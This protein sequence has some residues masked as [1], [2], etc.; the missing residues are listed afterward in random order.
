[1]EKFTKIRHFTDLIVWQEAHKLVLIIYK[2]TENFPQKEIFGIT[3]QVRRAITSVTANI[4]EGFSRFSYKDRIRFYL[5]SRGSLSE[6]ENFILISKDVGYIGEE[7][8]NNIWGQSEKVAT[9]INGLIKST[10]RLIK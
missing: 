5:L 2:I 10:K 7:E 4:S 1:M 6:V 8:F 9:I 3:N